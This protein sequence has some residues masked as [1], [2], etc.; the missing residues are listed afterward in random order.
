MLLHKQ[1]Q[2]IEVI[3]DET[4]HLKNKNKKNRLSL[5]KEDK[6]VNS[7]FFFIFVF[8]LYLWL[9]FFS[10]NFSDFVPSQALLQICSGRLG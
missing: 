8:V 2:V 7:H 9:K 1:L 5:K 4:G 6:P 3:K 10:A